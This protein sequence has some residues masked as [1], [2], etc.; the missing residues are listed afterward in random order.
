MTTKLCNGCGKD[1]KLIDF[2]SSASIF[3]KATGKVNICKSCLLGYVEPKQSNKYDLD[4]VKSA[5]RM[6]DKPFIQSLWDSSYNEA[7]ERGINVFRLYMKNIGMKDFRMLHWGNSEYDIDNSIVYKDEEKVIVRD[8]ELTEDEIND[9][10]SIFGRGFS[11]EDYAWL[12]EEYQDFKNR[13]ECDSKGME[14]LL[15]QIVLTELDIEKR[16]ANNEKVDAQL[17]TLQDLLGSSN[18]KPVQETGANS[19]EQETFGTLIKKY[20]NERPIPEPDER[21]KDVDGIS[22]YVK[23]F[24]TGHLARMLGKKDEDLEEVYWEEMSK[25]TVDEPEKQDDDEGDYVE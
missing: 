6:I 16:R 15:K 9:A 23:V 14:M 10:V 4:K 13:Y 22:R 3:N 1:V 12:I 8:V 19:I 18:L 24:F 11:V 2:Y 25:Y 21:W 17:K 7:N 20:E 5:L